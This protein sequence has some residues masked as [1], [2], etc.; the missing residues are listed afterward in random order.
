VRRSFVLPAMILFACA[1]SDGDADLST[2][3][4]TD[5]G[6]A[7]QSDGSLP[8]PPSGLV[9]GHSS[10]YLYR[11]DTA[12]RNVS[13]V[14]FF[15]G[16]GHVSDIALDETS[17]LYASNGAELFVVENNTA[18]CTKVAAG[19]F[20]NSLSFVPAGT[21]DAKEVLVGYEGGN[22]V[23]I[24]TASGATEKVGELGGGFE[25]SGDM[26]SVKDGKSFVTVKGPGCADCLVEIDPKTGVL[27]KNWGPLGLSDVFGLA[28]WGGEIYAFTDG[29]EVALVK[30]AGDELTVEKLSVPNAPADLSFRGAGSTTSAPVGEVR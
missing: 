21:L 12:T 14:G 27:T 7:F 15:A 30:L 6:T 11:I 29:G 23:K 3:P 10:T 4:N 28:F 5:G 22:Y 2:P 9:Y 18:R 16:C 8:P 26:V 24:D 25:S 20:P 19:A 1:K 17:T 13:E